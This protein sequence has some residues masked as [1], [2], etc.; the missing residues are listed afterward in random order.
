MDPNQ[1]LNPTQ[2][3][4]PAPNPFAET[5]IAPPPP[6]T[7]L[8]PTAEGTAPIPESSTPDPAPVNSST[9]PQSNG[10]VILFVVG[11][12]LLLV[13][14]GVIYLLALQFNNQGKVEV[15]QVPVSTPMP[16]ASP[17]PTPLSEEDIDKIDLG[18]PQTELNNIDS[19]VKQL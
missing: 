10:K 19:D 1:N 4:P 9:P 12:V 7:N 11:G 16:Q 18:D 5:P 15:A 2:P 3:Q 14:L 17:T 6:V 13:V 8:G